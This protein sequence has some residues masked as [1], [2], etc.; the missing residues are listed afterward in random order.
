MDRARVLTMLHGYSKS[1]DKYMRNISQLLLSR[2]NQNKCDYDFAYKVC[3]ELPSMTV[4]ELAD[5]FH[6]IKHTG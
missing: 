3:R 5:L 6:Y 4:T 1:N 2:L